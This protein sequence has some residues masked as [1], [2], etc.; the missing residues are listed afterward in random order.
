MFHC[1]GLGFK[2]PWIYGF[3]YYIPRPMHAHK[4]V[5]S[6]FLP[7]NKPIDREINPY[8]YSNRVKNLSNFGYP[9]S[10]RSRAAAGRGDNA[11]VGVLE[12][13][14]VRH[15]IGAPNV[16][17]GTVTTQHRGAWSRVIKGAAVRR[18]TSS[19]RPSRSR[20]TLPCLDTKFFCISLL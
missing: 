13:Y 6:R 20:S 16:P 14:H 9:L 17:S 5:G 12:A 19:F 18:T 7:I 1:D 3:G 4:S 8:S 2:N 15:W 11:W 10:S